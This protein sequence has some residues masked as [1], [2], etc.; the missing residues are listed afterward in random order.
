MIYAPPPATIKGENV[1]IVCIG[2][3][4]VSAGRTLPDN[5]HVGCDATGSTSAGSA[6][7]A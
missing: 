5:G 6:P 3:Y 4:P 7:P 1:V 2:P